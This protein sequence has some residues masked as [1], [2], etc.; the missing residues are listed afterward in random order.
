MCRRL[1][2]V[3]NVSYCVDAFDGVLDIDIV[4]FRW[5]SKGWCAILLPVATSVEL[6]SF[7]PSAY[8]DKAKPNTVNVNVIW[9]DRHTFFVHR[10]FF[11]TCLVYYTFPTFASIS[12]R[13]R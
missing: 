12:S 8:F 2:V 7:E 4:T 6:G 5:Y 1:S 9:T 10:L 3:F 13:N 11:F